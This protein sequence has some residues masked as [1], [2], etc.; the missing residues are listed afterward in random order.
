MAAAQADEQAVVAAAAQEL[1]AAAAELPPAEIQEAAPRP[2][3]PEDLETR[4]VE[5][6]L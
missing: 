5:G 2:Q 1:P 6:T 3:E 4:T